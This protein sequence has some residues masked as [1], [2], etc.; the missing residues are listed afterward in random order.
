MANCLYIKIF[1]Q[2]VVRNI[3]IKEFYQILLIIE[4]MHNGK[5]EKTC[6]KCESYIYV[7]IKSGN[8]EQTKL[9]KFKKWKNATRVYAYLKKRNW[10]N[11]VWTKWKN[12]FEIKN[13]LKAKWKNIIKFI[14][15]LFA[16]Y[17]L[18]IYNKKHLKKN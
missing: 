8:K 3:Y 14:K 17:F 16:I 1:Y 2:V 6:E 15:I 13:K 11:R 12:H 9:Q 5:Q 18:G 7:Y 10:I 4:L